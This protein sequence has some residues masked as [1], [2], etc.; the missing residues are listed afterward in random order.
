MQII[1]LTC[2]KR[3]LKHKSLQTLV[4][5]DR[6]HSSM[7]PLIASLGWGKLLGRRDRKIQ[8]EKSDTSNE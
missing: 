5:W 7:D 6:H 8:K 2:F 1:C 4:I 3:T